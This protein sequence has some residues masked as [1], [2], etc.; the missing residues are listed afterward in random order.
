M[1]VKIEPELL[2]KGSILVTFSLTLLR[3]PRVLPRQRVPPDDEHVHKHLNAVPHHA[4]FRGVRM[5]PYHR[6]FDRPQPVMPR[7]VEQL[8]VKPKPLN[9]LLPKNDFAWLPPKHL[10]PALCIHERQDRK[11]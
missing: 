7:Q 3:F 1:R 6:N 2:P 8:R 4:D 10:E 5:S 9:R 11:S